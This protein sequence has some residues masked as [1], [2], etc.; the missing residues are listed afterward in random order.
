MG[1][2][3]RKIV[4]LTEKQQELAA[5]YAQFIQSYAFH[6]VRKYRLIN[7]CDEDELESRLYLILCNL[8][9]SFKPKIIDKKYNNFKAFMLM[10]LKRQIFVTK[11]YEDR[12]RRYKTSNI[13]D[14]HC[15]IKTDASGYLDSSDFISK[16]NEE[17]KIVN[18]T[19]QFISSIQIDILLKE[20]GLTLNEMTVIRKIFYE[21]KKIKEI[22][23]DLEIGCPDIKKI[24]E[25]AL[26]KLRVFLE[27]NDYSY[28]CFLEPKYEKIEDD[29]PDYKQNEN[30]LKWTR[31]SLEAKKRR[32][33]NKRFESEI[34]NTEL[35]DIEI[36]E[37][38]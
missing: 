26:K 9:Q 21:N 7:K 30:T 24:K 37:A 20:S 8:A 23:R 11:D 14:F 22:S 1:R 4:K 15:Y 29:I 38:I 12:Y 34:E 32:E 35:E 27:Q 2:K 5:K 28:N 16:I 17:D 6:A 36:D 33:R 13:Y 10:N 25:R 19:K 31:R 18:N 3:F